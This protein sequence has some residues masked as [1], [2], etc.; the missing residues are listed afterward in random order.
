MTVAPP[1]DDRFERYRGRVDQ[2]LDRWL[3][4]AETNP[5]HLHAAMRYSVVNGGKRVRPLLAYGA[6]ESL[7]APAEKADAIACSLE[8]IHAYSLVHDDLP[9]MDDDDL[10]RGKPSCHRAFDEATAILAGDALQALAFE[11]LARNSGSAAV[12]LVI[13]LAQACGSQGMAGGQAI[14]LAAVGETMGLPDLR[15]MHELKTGALIRAA[16]VM[17]ATAVATAADNRTNL[18]TYGECIGLAFQVK[19][20]ILDVESDT[21]TL[22]KP[23]GSDVEAAKPTFPSLLGLDASKALALELCDRAVTALDALPGDTT[24]LRRLADFIIHRHQ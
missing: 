9:A 18:A 12:Q 4:A 19:D 6:A 8:L 11:I 20:D 5:P 3:P 23:Q 1:V 17:P 24:L 22:G 10:R 13:E 14:D 7:D 2:L 21:E 15:L 16:V